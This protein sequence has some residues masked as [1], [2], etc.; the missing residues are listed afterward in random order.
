MKTMKY[1]VMVMSVLGLSAGVANAFPVP[2]PIETQLTI[3]NSTTGPETAAITQVSSGTEA[4][5]SNQVVQAAAKLTLT[6]YEDRF[7]GGGY[8][9]TLGDCKAKL[10]VYASPRL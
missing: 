3:E 5:R 8:T 10:D 7:Q 2:T 9:L 4:P 6:S 1:V